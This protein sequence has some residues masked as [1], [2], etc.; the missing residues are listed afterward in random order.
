[1]RPP[2]ELAICRCKGATK[3][4]MG[5]DSEVTVIGTDAEQVEVD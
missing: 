1:M 3:V 5:E 2:V 4:G